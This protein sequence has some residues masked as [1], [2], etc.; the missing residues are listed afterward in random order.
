MMANAIMNS[1]NDL[2]EVCRCDG[3]VSKER[4]HSA[5]L[6]S[7]SLENPS[8]ETNEFQTATMFNGACQTF[9][10]NVTCI[11]RSNPSG[12][13]TSIDD[14]CVVVCALT[15][16]EMP[17]TVFC[18]LRETIAWIKLVRNVR[19]PKAISYKKICIDLLWSVD[20]SRMTFA[21]P[22]G[23]FRPSL[24]VKRDITKCILVVFD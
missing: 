3:F 17:A 22:I 19:Y 18:H 13:V 1:K 11:V 20:V 10:M 8:F 9:L 4:S 23:T 6:N 24:W 12:F 7:I 2:V 16:I 5:A 15:E 14:G 21:M